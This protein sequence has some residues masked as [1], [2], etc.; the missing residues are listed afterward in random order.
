VRKTNAR[1]H[2]LE[3]YRGVLS[4]AAHAARYRNISC[5]QDRRQLLPHKAT[6][7][8]GPTHH[9]MH[10]AYYFLLSGQVEHRRGSPYP[11]PSQFGA[12]NESPL[13]STKLAHKPRSP[14]RPASSHRASTSHHPHHRQGEAWLRPRPSPS[15]IA[16][17]DSRRQQRWVAQGQGR[18]QSPADIG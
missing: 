12:S 7:P 8:L 17:E 15:G 3:L 6:Q 9:D 14:L 13:C 1:F 4:N 11:Y 5:S 18:Q 16:Q 10:G 2:L